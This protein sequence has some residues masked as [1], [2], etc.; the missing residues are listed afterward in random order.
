MV[1]LLA[2]VEEEPPLTTLCTCKMPVEMDTSTVPD[3]NAVA[4]TQMCVN[5]FVEKLD[6]PA[7]DSVVAVVHDAPPLFDSRIVSV[8]VKVP[9]RFTVVVLAFCGSCWITFDPAVEHVPAS[10]TVIGRLSG[11]VMSPI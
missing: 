3:V 1:V 2:D 4:S 8:A 10:T 7:A 5:P 11:L 9:A 6:V